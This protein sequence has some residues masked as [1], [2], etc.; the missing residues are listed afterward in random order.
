MP[1]KIQLISRVLGGEIA[2][3]HQSNLEGDRVIEFAEIKT[4]QL[5][6]LV[7]TVNESVS[8][9]EHLSGGFGHVQ[10]IGKEALNGGKRFSV[11]R[12]DGAFLENFI[13][14][15]F[16]KSGGKLIDESADTEDARGD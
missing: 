2:A 12:L 1:G 4:R 15:H 9:N 8:V 14:E 13:E 7:K 6:D 5:L 16:A 10:I 3:Y 11:E